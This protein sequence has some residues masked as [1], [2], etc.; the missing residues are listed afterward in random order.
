[1]G[2]LDLD[3]LIEQLTDE[4]IID[5]VTELGADRYKDTEEFIIFPTICHNEISENASM[6]LY[7][8]KS[9]KLF[10]C[11]TECD[12][13]FNIF[14]LFQKVYDIKEI[15]YNFYDILQKILNKT[16]IINL[17]PFEDKE[18]QS[19]I[20]K[21][22]RKKTK[23]DLEIYDE[24]ILNVFSKHYPIEWIAEGITNE[25]MDRFNILY[26]ISRNKIIIPHYDIDSNLIGIR[27]RALN[28]YEL[29]NK[30]MPIEIENKWYSHPL[31]FNLYGLN[32]N[33]QQIEKHHRVIIYEGEKS[34]LKHNVFFPTWSI[35]V[36]SCGSTLNKNQLNLLIYNFKLLEIVI[37]FDKEYINFNDEKGRKYFKK[38]EELCKKY[39]NYCNFSF[40]FD[41]ENLL[42][43]KDSPI[44]RG[45]K[46]FESLYEK[47]IKIGS[48]LY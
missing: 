9:N 3:I 5:L 29:E 28:D 32:I 43:E 37:A 26:S 36:A 33:K 6:K 21:Y 1:M 12:E 14:T 30:Y 41:K 13:S 44:D 17:R 15:E 31:S 40:I 7:Y 18:Y 39:S 35:A 8:Y 4:N 11:Y 42:K 20:D 47:R 23:K 38:L 34:V 46:V 16:D 25:S 10:H 48:R 19:E 2:K 22:R 24:K 45:K 27:G